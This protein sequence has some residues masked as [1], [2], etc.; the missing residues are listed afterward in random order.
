MQ[1]R[2]RSARESVV[3]WRASVDADGALAVPRVQR[4]AASV[5]A[6]HVESGS[7]RAGVHRRNAGVTRCR[8]RCVIVV[9]AGCV[10][11][12]AGSIL[13]V[14]RVRID[15]WYGAVVVSDVRLDD[16]LAALVIISLGNDDILLN[17][18]VFAGEFAIDHAHTHA[19]TYILQASTVCGGWAYWAPHWPRCVRSI[20]ARRLP[21]CRARR[22]RH[23][24]H[25]PHCCTMCDV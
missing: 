4:T 23:S 24:S 10:V 20:A 21:A 5:R 18:E 3:A 25:W 1:I 13:S 9:C 8:A 17:V 11:G 15:G 2:C 12:C 6:T 7:A 14:C 19:L 16:L 22:A